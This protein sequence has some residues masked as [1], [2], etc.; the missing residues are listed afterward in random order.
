M[1][2]TSPHYFRRLVTLPHFEVIAL[3]VWPCG[4]PPDEKP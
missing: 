2:A 3:R 1:L 4:G